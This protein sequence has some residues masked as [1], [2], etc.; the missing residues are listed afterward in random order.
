MKEIG[1]TLLL[2]L[3]GFIFSPNDH[4]ANESATTHPGKEK[5]ILFSKDIASIIF[6]NCTPCHRSGQV[7][8]FTLMNYNEVARHS[9]EIVELTA[10]R[11]MPP[12]K[13]KH[14]YGNFFGERRLTDAQIKLIADWVKSGMEPGE[15]KDTPP[16]P[17]Y[18][19]N[20]QL[21]TPDLIV[22]MPEAMTIPAEGP[23]FFMSF[24]IPLDLPEDKYIKAVDVL[25][26]NRGVVHHT[27][28]SMDPTGTVSKM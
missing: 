16:A 26:A 14:G 20:W 21:G 1:I 18:A 19:D 22:Y 17:E 24:V 2:A 3:S 12:W 5:K 10:N 28:I 23:D 7:A 9:K 11:Q 27:T 13:A 8:P 4:S 25:P 15:E 6:K